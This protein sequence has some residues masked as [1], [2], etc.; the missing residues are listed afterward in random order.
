[1][2]R[3]IR[4]KK[5][6]LILITYLFILF[7]FS[8]TFF[9]RNECYL[10]VIRNNNYDFKEKIILNDDS[11]KVID[12]YKLSRK[13]R[14]EAAIYI[15]SNLTLEELDSPSS[16]IEYCYIFSK[17]DKWKYFKCGELDKGLK[18]LEEGLKEEYKDLGFSRPVGYYGFYSDDDIKHMIYEE[19]HKSKEM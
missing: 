18:D 6:R 7:T 5:C 14:Y 12:S 4:V 8:L 1:M 10:N 3:N 16:W 19:E 11:I 2:R 15:N 17:D 13:E 9:V